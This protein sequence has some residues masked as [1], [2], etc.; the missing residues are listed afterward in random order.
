MRPAQ[1]SPAEIQTPLFL[2][3]FPE[4]TSIFSNECCLSQSYV[5]E[6]QGVIAVVVMMERN[7]GARNGIAHWYNA[8]PCLEKKIAQGS[9][10]CWLVVQESIRD[11]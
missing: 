1:N 9:V 2:L 5:A 8:V 3:K 7:A 6:L 4:M 10:E 11:P